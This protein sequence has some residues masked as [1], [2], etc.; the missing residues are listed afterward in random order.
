MK[1]IDKLNKVNSNRD[2]SYSFE[3][4]PPKTDLGFGNL[5]DRLGR[6]AHLEPNFISC[7]WGTGGSSQKYSL[8]LCSTAQRQYGLDTMM[9]LTCTNMGKDK[10]DSALKAAQ[11]AGIRNILALRGDPPRGHEYWT[12]TDTDFSHAIDLVRYIRQWYGDYFCIGVAGYPEGHID[13]P[14]QDQ[15]MNYLKAKIEA[16]A[17]FVMT[18][19]FYDTDIFINWLHTCREIGIQVPIIPGIM[20][21]PTYQSFRR[22]IHLCNIKVPKKMM[23]DLDA[24]KSDDEKVKE[25]GVQ[26]AVS[27]IQRLYKEEG[28]CHFH[29]STLNLERSTRLILEALQIH[30]PKEKEYSN[31][32]LSPW[33]VVHDPTRAELWDEF[34]NGRYGDS[35][36]PAYGEHTFSGSQILPT[37]QA[38]SKWGQ[39]ESIQDLTELFVKYIKGEIHSLPWCEESLQTESETIRQRLIEM[40]QRGYWTVS[41]Q[42]AVNGVSSEDPIY[43]WG[44]KGGYV[45][46]K[47]FIEF[48]VS[49]QHID[50]ILNRISKDKSIS[51]YAINQ[52]DD[53]RTNI[54]D[55]DA[56]NTVTWGVFPCKEII[57]STIIERLSFQA[58]KDE[59]FEL[60]TEW[61]EEYPTH[62]KSQ[63][64]LKEVKE[65]YWLVNVVHHD[66]HKPDFLFNLILS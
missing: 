59:A 19:L 23:M 22:M 1:V 21:I 29:I 45:Y 9:H 39:P 47:A 52:K 33:T 43:G 7:T 34:P 24:I 15:E 4:F 53:F 38:I 54:S 28:I 50:S 64:L 44:P 14:N 62:S 48:F 3:Y 26:L 58:W 65:T 8:E 35:R 42:P 5:I 37:S 10:I 49:D 36:S 27:M 57:Q 61:E 63:K 41:S 12:P 56:Q 2:L 16:G 20:P 13:C 18:Q 55:P 66:F 25:Y 6:M 31:R 40:N 30:K 46:Q 51:Y 32:I 11:E 17:D 60:W